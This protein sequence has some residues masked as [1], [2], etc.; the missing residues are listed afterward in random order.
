MIIL[1]T[2]TREKTNQMLSNLCLVCVVED[3][4]IIQA[5]NDIG[6]ITLFRDNIDNLKT[7]KK[8]MTNL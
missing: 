2:V 8:K 3:I 1:G 5:I 4:I 7:R 6:L